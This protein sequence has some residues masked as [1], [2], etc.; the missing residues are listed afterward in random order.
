[1]STIDF[2]PL[3]QQLEKSYTFPAEYLFKFI[4]PEK[5]ESK[6]KLLKLFAKDADI[7]FKSSSGG[8]YSGITIKQTMNSADEIIDIYKAAGELKGVVSL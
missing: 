8:K 2:N 3:K 1:M 5:S 4:A 7:S 6:E